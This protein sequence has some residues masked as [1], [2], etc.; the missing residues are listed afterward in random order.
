MG[1]IRAYISH[2]IRGKYGKAATDAQMAEN[3]TKAINFGNFMCKEFPNI[4]WYVPGEHDEF[5]LVCY[6]NKLLTEKQI[7]TVDCEI[8]DKCNFMVV[9]S[10]DDYISRGMQVEIDHC[11]YT[12]KPI[13]SAVDGSYE[14]YI[15]RLIHAINCYLTSCMR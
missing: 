4:Q 3:N 10:P 6:R 13:I 15:A 14:E 1:Q 11:V 12:H 7:L 5:V 8:I 9:Y 2:S